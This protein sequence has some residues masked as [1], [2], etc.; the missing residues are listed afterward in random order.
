MNTYTDQ[1]KQS[2]VPILRRYGVIKAVLFGS[3]VKGKDVPG[4]IDIL[5]QIDDD[6]SLLQ[7]VALKLE[8]EQVLQKSVDLVEY[9]TVKPRLRESILREQ[10]AIL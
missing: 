5:V 4:D 7:F 8:L 3:A 1:V 6:I 2:I 9:D 10:E